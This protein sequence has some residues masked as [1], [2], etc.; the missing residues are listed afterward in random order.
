MI[1]NLRCWKT[2]CFA[3]HVLNYLNNNSF[4][5]VQIL[6]LKYGPIQPW[7]YSIPPKRGWFFRGFCRCLKSFKPH[8]WL[9]S[10]NPQSTSLMND[11][12][13]FDVPLPFKPTFLNMNL[14]DG[15]T[16]ITVLIEESA[17]N[18]RRI[19]DLLSDHLNS[20]AMASDHLSFSTI[21]WFGSQFPEIQLLLMQCIYILRLVLGTTLTGLVGKIFGV[22][23][24]LLKLNFSCG[25][26]FMARSKP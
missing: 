18:P 14:I 26:Y 22:S 4:Y 2:A 24:L 11:P 23:M 20:P 25:C 5:W 6:N 3:K 9:R 15:N 8:L 13:Y 17:W 12:W 1:C 19:N 16:E 10:F 7:S 21:D